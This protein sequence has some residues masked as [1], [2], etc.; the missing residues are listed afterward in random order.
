MYVLI[1]IM[2]VRGEP[3]IETVVTDSHAECLSMHRWVKGRTLR[4]QKP[5][6]LSCLQ[7]PYES[8]NEELMP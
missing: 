8:F 6:T 4:D 3:V 2:M 1:I 7:V 5:V